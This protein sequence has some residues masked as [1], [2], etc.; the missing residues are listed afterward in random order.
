MDP[1]TPAREK[2]WTRLAL[3][4]DEVREARLDDGEV[5]DDGRASSSLETAE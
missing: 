3:R 2:R 1:V 5:D 4:C